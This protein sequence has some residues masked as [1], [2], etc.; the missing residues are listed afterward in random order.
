MKRILVATKNPGKLKEFKA[1][2]SELPV[3]IVSLSNVGI[4][5]D[6]I[7]NGKSYEENS[8]KKAL[9][10]A[11]KSGL[12]TI[13]DDGG[14]EIEALNFEPGIRSRRWLGHEATDE[15]LVNHMIK[16]SKDLPADNRTAYFRTIVSVATPHGRVFQQFGE[17]KGI[18]AKKP[19]LK[20]NKGYPYRS[21]FYLPE[22]K[23]YYHES[24]LSPE[25]EKIYNHRYKAVQKLIPKI[26]E[27]L[28]DD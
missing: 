17:V 19:L 22:I 12:I 6:V 5:E 21:F 2:L 28:K 9:F 27:L 7:E 15:E 20:L 14:I 10:Y 1:F 11:K 3:E 18:I 24:D 13:S 25:E 23:K 16:I 8:R 26:K 4:T